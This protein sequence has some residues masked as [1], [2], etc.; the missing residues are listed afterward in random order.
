[1]EN[2]HRL[3]HRET[4]EIIYVAS[5]DG[6]NLDV[7]EAVEIRS[8]RCPESFETVCKNGV[9]RKCPKRHRD[10]KRHAHLNG[11]TSAQRFDKLM[12]EIESLKDEVK[13]LKDALGL[14]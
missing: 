14:E 4:G 8:N 1:M 5:L 6:E 9:I 12:A 2:W 11:M 13:V 7:W 3:K 10:H